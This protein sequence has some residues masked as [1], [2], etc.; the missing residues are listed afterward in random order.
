MK[1]NH[2]IQSRFPKHNVG[3][4][5]NVL[6]NKGTGLAPGQYIV[7]SVNQRSKDKDRHYYKVRTTANDCGVPFSI[8]F[9]WF[10]QGTVE[11]AS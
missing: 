1:L 10:D 5:I 11:W 2:I 6:R 3:K 7:T 8:E 4:T 9:I